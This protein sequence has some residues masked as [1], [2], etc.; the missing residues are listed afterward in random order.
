MS[1]PPRP[2]P[3]RRWL[4]CCLMLLSGCAAPEPRLLIETRTIPLDLPAHLLACLPSP[5]PPPAGSTQRDAADFVIRLWD[6]GQDC[7][8]KLDAVRGLVVHP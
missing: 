4:P 8:S 6:A 7:R 2:V 3:M 1:E 5:D